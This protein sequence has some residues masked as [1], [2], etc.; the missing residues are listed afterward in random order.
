[1][2]NGGF[3]FESQQVVDRAVGPCGA[4]GR[5]DGPV[6]QAAAVDVSFGRPPDARSAHPRGPLALA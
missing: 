4:R 6:K 2:A 1:M 3:K 5:S